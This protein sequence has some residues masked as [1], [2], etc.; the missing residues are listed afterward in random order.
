MRVDLRLAAPAVAAWTSAGVLVGV[1]AAAGPSTIVLWAVAVLAAG[2]ALARPAAGGL[3]IVA[4]VAAGAGLAATAVAA[5]GPARTPASLERAVDGGTSVLARIALEARTVAG[6]RAP[7]AATIREWQDGRGE[8]RGSVPVVLFGPVPAA[9]AGDV[10]RVRVGLEHADPGER[11]AYLAFP[12]GTARVVAHAPAGLAAVDGLRRGLG[13]VAERLGGDGGALLPGLAIGDT[14]AVPD[15]LDADMTTASLTHLTAVS[16]ANCA[17]VVTL[18]AVG[19]GLA[20][21]GRRGRTIAALLAL[22]GFV[23]LVTP[24]P[25]VLRA[26]VMAAIA[27]AAV[28]A[29]RPA[30]G[31]PL[32]ALAVL[33]L[34]AADP[35]LARD[36]GFVLSVLATGALLVLAGPLAARIARVLPLP[37]ARVLAIPL[38]AQLACQ[39]VLVLL[40]PG[41]PVWAVPANVLAEPAAPAATVLGMAACLVLPVLHPLGVALAAAAWVPSAWIAAVARGS[42]HLPAARV[43]WLPGVAGAALLAAATLAVLVAVLASGLPRRVAVLALAGAIAGGG[44]VA[45]VGTVERIAGRSGDWEYAACDVGQGDAFLVRSAGRVALVD[46]GPDPARVRGCLDTLGVRRLDL[47]VLTHYDLDH[48]GGVSAVVGRTALALVGPS[49]GADDDR[50]SA[51]VRR[52]GAQVRSVTEGATGVLGD[53]DWRVVWP[54]PDA[55]VELGNE[56]SVTV[57]FDARR[58]CR[59]ACLSGLFLGDL[60]ERAQD[61]LAGRGETLA[62]DVV[63]V[64]HHGSA[65]QS[66]RLYRLVHATVGLIG[67][68]AHND[69]GHPTDTALGILRSV[70]TA[71]ARTDRE[72]LVLVSGSPERVRVWSERDPGG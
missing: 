14:S 47:L 6:S 16:G 45:T 58:G 28:A 56:S 53:L 63:K 50:V 71:I 52:G 65:N 70:G 32:L 18:V 21:V 43:P 39:P 34:L 23:V 3:A 30:R 61:L 44:V 60:D 55:P 22:A 15:G 49:A 10:V 54:A 8:A 41:M 5:N 19:A 37:L 35:W 36:Y 62:A 67:V 12:R 7:V 64:A 46:T 11:A 68:G 42:A 17:V 59:T 26:A 29:G 2:V 38:S 1:P 31:V 40:D 66:A 13:V 57:R 24:Q 4:L 69:Y 72:G 20:G 25:S 51:A 33:V 9:R 48:V 27:L